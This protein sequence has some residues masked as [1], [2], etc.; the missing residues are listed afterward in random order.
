MAKV[1]FIDESRCTGCDRCQRNCAAHAISIDPHR[2]VAVIDYLKCDGC[3]KCLY[4]CPQEGAIVVTKTTDG[5]K[6]TVIH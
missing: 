4:F 5:C 2:R 6:G 3:G 1:L